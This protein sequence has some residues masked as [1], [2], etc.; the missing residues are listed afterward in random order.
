MWVISVAQKP[1]II[2]PNINLIWHYYQNGILR[3]RSDQDFN[4]HFEVFGHIFMS[5]DFP[6]MDQIGRGKA[7]VQSYL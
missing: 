7:D 3:K 4:Q 6:F 1:S 2:S 5:T